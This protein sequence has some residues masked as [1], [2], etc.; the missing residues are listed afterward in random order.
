MGIPNIFKGPGMNLSKMSK[1]ATTKNI[2]IGAVFIL[3][4]CAAFFGYYKY[5][6]PLINR[7]KTANMEH[8]T[9]SDIPGGNMRT[10]EVL[11]F[12]ADWCP[13]CKKVKEPEG[14][15]MWDKLQSS[16]RVKEGT[17]INGYVIKYVGK[18]CTNNKDPTTQQTLDK[19]KVE[20]FPTFKISRGN[21]IIEYDAKPEL[22]SLE[23]FILTTLSQ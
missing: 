15:S 10:A 19:Y 11:F 9:N 23:R 13:H 5:A 22:E 4:I 6:K 3:F 20:G 16:E 1:K 8:N 14:S 17:I 2:L 21:E 12:Y 7:K 18:D